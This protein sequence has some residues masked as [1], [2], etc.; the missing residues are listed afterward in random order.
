MSLLIFLPGRW[1][2]V[3]GLRFVEGLGFSFFGLM[4]SDSLAFAQG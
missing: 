2:R 4:F 3:E 1:L